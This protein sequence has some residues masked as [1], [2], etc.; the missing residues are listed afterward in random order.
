LVEGKILY[1]DIQY[2]N[3]G[4]DDRRLETVT[5]TRFRASDNYLFKGQ[6]D[7]VN[8]PGSTPYPTVTIM[9]GGNSTRVGGPDDESAILMISTA[10]EVQ[11][12]Q[13]DEFVSAYAAPGDHITIFDTDYNIEGTYTYDG[14]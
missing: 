10:I 9:V 4:I 3:T 7:Q 14:D 6:F 2:T 11:P 8:L 5:N 13:I 1:S 12:E